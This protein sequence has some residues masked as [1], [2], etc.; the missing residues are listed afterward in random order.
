[1]K[2]QSYYILTIILGFITLAGCYKDKGN[3]DYHP[4]NVL[5]ITSSAYTYNVML[6]DSLKI[7]VN[8]DQ[9]MPDAAGIRYEWVMYPSTVA[10]LTRRTLDT[11]KNLVAKITEDPGTYVLILYAK[12]RK[13]EVE[14]QKTFTVNVL[15]AYSEGWVIVEEDAGKCDLAMV[16]PTDAIFR[17]AYSLN[18]N[19]QYL[20]A[21]TFRVPTMKTNRNDQKVFSLYPGSLEQMN[22]ANFRKIA[23]PADVFWQVPAPFKPQEIFFNCDNEVALCDGKPHFRS[24]AAAGVIKFNFPPTGSYYLSPHEIYQT[25]SGYVFYDTLGRKFLKLD[26]NTVT[27]IPMNAAP[28]G[29][30]FD[31]NNIGKRIIY[32]EVNTG[33]QYNAIFKNVNNDSLFAFVFNPTLTNPAVNRYDG[34]TAPG[35][36]TA[37]SFVMSRSLPYLYYASGNQIYR[38]DIPAKTAAP[39]YTFPAGTEISAMKMY[40]NQKNSADVNNNKLIAVATK[41]GSEGKLYYFPIATTGLFTGNTYSKVFGGFK[42]INDIAYKSLK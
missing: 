18:N 19:G 7:D 21:G 5:T 13:T 22:F 27:L 26:A 11:T 12:D 10:P 30:I 37:K 36:T 42:Q 28:T 3:Y 32:S 20:P 41:E 40:V 33:G 9:T 23:S 38:L 29:A 24:Y 1:M 14:Y 39:I 8:I 16:T 6:P 4:I 31:M 15:T 2:K 25:T 35:I 34:L 17:N